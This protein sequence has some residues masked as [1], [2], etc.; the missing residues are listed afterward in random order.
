MVVKTKEEAKSNFEAAIAY[1]PARY[2][3]GVTKADWLTPAKSP[4]A[5]TNFAAAI[6]KAVAA[7]T[8]QKAIAA[9]TNEDWKNA[10]IAKGVP[11]IGDRIRGALDKWGANWGP[12]Y[13]QVVAKVAALAP[14]TTDWR[15]NINKR[16]VPTVEAWRK[17]AGKT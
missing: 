6:T 7:K 8:R 4:Q 16:L 11:I 13:D 9:M 1:I 15:A 17:A 14:K 3:A 10:A 12:M 5:E 2:E